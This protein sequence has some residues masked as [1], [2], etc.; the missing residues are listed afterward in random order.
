MLL[1]KHQRTYYYDYLCRLNGRVVLETIDYQN[2]IKYLKVY[3]GEHI[4]F[5][6]I[7]DFNSLVRIWDITLDV[8]GTAQYDFLLIAN[9][10]VIHIDIKNY[11][12]NYRF[13]NGNFISEKGYVHQG[14]ISQLE[15]AHFKLE[16][17]LKLN[18][19]TYKVSSRILFINPEFQLQNYQGNSKI[20]F[21]NQLSEVLSYLESLTSNDQDLNLG[22]ILVN[23]HTEKTYDRIHY[24]PYETIKKGV[25][26][27]QCNKIN[28]YSEISQR[29]VICRCGYTISKHDYILEAIQDISMFKPEGFTRNELEK[30]T[31]INATT[32]K[33]YLQNYCVKIGSFKD[34]KYKIKSE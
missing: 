18:H 20:I 16:Q 15:R 23:H 1:K 5:D 22:M 19:F 28:S 26:C 9:D 27:K 11:S 33:R 12:G 2:L 6:Y 14:L 4:F 25:R 24:Y 30:Y 21:Y 10:T 29:I 31:N 17:F 8:F 3:E 13:D 32:L 7:K 34:A